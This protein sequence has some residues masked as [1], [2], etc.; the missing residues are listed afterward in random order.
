MWVGLLVCS[1]FILT[2]A[3]ITRMIEYKNGTRKLVKQDTLQFRSQSAIL[4]PPIYTFN[5]I[6]YDCTNAS[7]NSTLVKTI[8]TYM[9][10]QFFPHIKQCSN[11]SVSKLDA[12]IYG[13]YYTLPCTIN[14]CSDTLLS[15]MEDRSM[16]LIDRQLYVPSI[17]TVFIS[18]RL[19]DYLAIADV[20][21]SRIFINGISNL[22]SKNILLHEWGH[23]LGLHHAT[24]HRD[25]YGDDTCAMG[26]ST[27]RSL[28]FNAAHSHLL[29]WINITSISTIRLNGCRKLISSLPYS[30]DQSYYISYQKPFLLIHKIHDP[31]NGYTRLVTLLK[32]I[33][34]KYSIPGT[35]MNI[36]WRY[37]NNYIYLNICK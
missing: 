6:L 28:C 27:N 19:C 22:F 11:N 9:Y 23:N 2:Y 10:E 32:P 4:K 14:T 37:K 8:Y 16:Q 29:K 17:I 13:P 34:K 18:P 25:E 5:I 36:T 24:L 21:G 12:F 15:S 26:R 20:L 31:D 7:Y 30:I 3:T 33:Q 35:N 1:W